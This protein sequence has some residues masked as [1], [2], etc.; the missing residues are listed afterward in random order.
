MLSY[1]YKWPGWD[2]L[3]KL[4]NEDIANLNRARMVAKAEGDKKFNEW[5]ADGS[6][7]PSL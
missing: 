4:V 1:E 7:N 3:R 5:A 6:F 2:T